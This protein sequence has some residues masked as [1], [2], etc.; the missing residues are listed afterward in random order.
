ME[1]VPEPK[2][3]SGGLAAEGFYKLLGRPR[4]DPLTVLVR[5]TAQNSW[6]ARLDTGQ[7]V[8]F[9]I[10]GW[11]LENSERKALRER[12]FVEAGS[13][14]GTN[15]EAELASRRL[16]GLYITDRN[17]K[18]LGGPVRADEEDP[19]GTYDWVDFVLN[20]GEANTHAHTGGTYGFGKT[21]AYVVSSANAVVI[22]SRTVHKG[23]VQSR[24]IACAIGEKFSRNR[25]QYTGRHWWAASGAEAPIPVTGREADRIA[26]LIGMPEFQDGATGTNLLIISPELGGRSP[27]QAM[28]FVAESVTWHLWPKL[29]RRRGKRAMEIEVSWNGEVVRI[30][31]PEE[32]PPLHGFAQAFQPIIEGQ[33]D[34]RT[35][36][37]PGLQIVS[38]RCSKPT[39]DVGVLAMV[40]L[41]HR[42]RVKVDDGSDPEDDEAPKPAAMI[43]G[44]CHHVALMRT[45]ELVV[46]YME[47]PAP[48]EGGTEWAAVFR[49]ND[50]HDR[51]F[52][53]AEPPTH[54]SWSPALLSKSAEKTIVNVGLREIRKAL[55]LRWGQR[56]DPTHAE[57]ASTALIADELA[58]LLGSVDGRGR[59]TRAGETLSSR[60][61]T[62][63]PRVD[64]AFSAP[65]EVDRE[66]A[67][68]ARLRVSPVPGSKGT[69]LRY[70]VAA[71]LEGTSAD[72]DLDPRLAVIQARIANQSTGVNGLSGSLDIN[73]THPVEVELVVRRGPETTVLFDIDAEAL[74]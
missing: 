40:P 74:A 10:Q 37:V 47:G 42:E 36:T 62:A 9:T 5:E 7:P 1:W 25:K 18:G 65:I 21:I 43:T 26:R 14:R 33:R 35:S 69:K 23:R 8:D 73:F 53:R 44:V 2:P 30:P 12:V 58:H 61:G 70:S 64:F 15:L 39:A 49:V 57:V 22:H 56:R 31:R 19:H 38:I 48:P 20:V 45:P 54:D 41:V 32:R 46:D 3:P 52:A 24:L 34:P 60:P 16:I 59:G 17:T 66:L 51:P 72:A 4:L 55:D 50:E 68:M 67:T 6:D 71:A 63:R 13:A 28:R 29:M 11:E 27:E